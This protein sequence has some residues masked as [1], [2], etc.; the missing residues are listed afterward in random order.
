MG[1]G[2]DAKIQKKTRK[3]IKKKKHA[4]IAQTAN[5]LIWA[6]SRMR[7]FNKKQRNALEKT[8][9]I[10]K[11]EESKNVSTMATNNGPEHAVRTEGA[12][13]D[14]FGCLSV[15]MLKSSSLLD[16]RATW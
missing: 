14:S 2:S 16:S 13:A 5:Q 1:S 8:M 12:V 7:K 9:Q 11:N 6:A 3:C 4:N 15:S 10:L